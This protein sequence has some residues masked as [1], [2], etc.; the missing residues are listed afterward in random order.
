MMDH[1]LI[2]EVVQI[3]VGAFLG[4]GMTQSGLDK[5]IDWQGNR[6]WLRDHFSKTNLSPFV[7]PMLMIVLILEVT[8]GLILIF[9]TGMGIVYGDNS[10]ILIGLM[11]IAVNLLALFFGQRLAKDYEGA[12]V[13]VNYFILTIIGLLTFH[14]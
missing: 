2:I 7:T 4:I 1:F 6:S 13:L 8:G 14:I 12:A 10:Y 9:G 3:L 11:I 5:I